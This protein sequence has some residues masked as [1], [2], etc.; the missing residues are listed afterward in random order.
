MMLDDSLM[1]YGHRVGL[2][3]GE[4][5]CCVCVFHKDNTAP[6]HWINI[7]MLYFSPNIKAVEFLLYLSPIDGQID[8]QILQQSPPQYI[9][10]E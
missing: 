7:D 10:N 6:A 8:K 5:V 2:G 4:V 3:E 1:L 9:E